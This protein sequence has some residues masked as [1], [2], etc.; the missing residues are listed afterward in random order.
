M[1]RKTVACAAVLALVGAAAATSA[2]A[3]PATQ[4]IWRAP[5]TKAPRLVVPG[6]DAPQRRDAVAIARGH[7]D[8]N[9]G[10]Y[11]VDADEDLRV[12]DV[13]GTPTG[14]TVRFGQVHRGLPVFGAQYLVHLAGG[15]AGAAVSS[16]NGHVFTELDSPTTP[17]L[18]AAEA[19]SLVPLRIRP[20]VADAVSPEGLTIVPVGDG[21]LAYEFVVTG[22]SF[23][24]P[25][26]RRVFINA[27]TGGVVLSYG[28]LRYDGAVTG[29]G[30]TAHGREVTLNA[31]Q[32]G[33]SFELRDRGRSMFSVS[34]GE[35]KT[36]DVLGQA[37]YNPTDGNLVRSSSS[38]FSGANTSSG[39]VDAHWG[40]GEVYEFYL[41]LGRDSIDGMGTT[42]TSIVNAAD[43][44]TGGPLFNAFWD[45]EK[46]IY[47]NP[48]PDELYPLSADLD[49]VGHELTHGVTQSSAGL[50]YLNQSG[51]M[52][53][54]YADYFGQAIDIT[55][56][57]APPGEDGFVGEDLCKVPEPAEWECPLRDLNDGRTT[58]DYLY[59]LSDFDG[60][61]V[62]DN[63][64]IYAGA[65][66]DVR[67][68]LGG[69]KTD[70]IVLKALTEFTTPLDEFIDGR[71]SIVEAARALGS[72][73]EDIALIESIFDAKGI[74]TGWDD[75]GQST[76]RTLVSGIFQSTNYASPQ[77][78]GPRFVIA[79][80]ADMT[81]VE[82]E[83]MQIYVGSIDGS[84]SLAKVGEDTNP[85]TFNDEAP[86]IFGSKVVWTHIAATSSGLDADV[87]SRKLGGGVRAVASGAPWQWYPS[88]DAKTI[89]WEQIRTNSDVWMRRGSRDPVR[90]AGG[91]TEQWLPQ[92]VGDWVAWWLPG[93]GSRPMGISMKNVVTGKTATIKAPSAR[94]F[95][96]PPAV[97]PGYVA[98]Y[99]DNNA[100]GLGSIMKAK[101]GRTA[102]TA[103]VPED[104][105]LSPVWVGG[106]LTGM[107]SGPAL[108]AGS[109]FVA[110][111][112]ERALADKFVARAPVPSARVGR[113]VWLVA[114]GGGTPRLATTARGDQGFPGM[115]DGDLVLWFDGRAARTD[116]LVNR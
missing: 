106:R 66:W 30:R 80:H 45:G 94:A 72:P 67:Q 3:R 18:T 74:V 81:K 19:T 12:L 37:V 46:M 52:D 116:L 62:H 93:D 2:A 89:V 78:S 88:I 65:L 14:D 31:F 23:G 20:M 15:P 92:V 95:L 24:A 84:G 7:L 53:E 76:E 35:I 22:S 110:Y 11:H 90:V 77:V 10:L 73:A 39:A 113:D 6:R 50:V 38:E 101:L 91:P 44:R 87:H 105:E 48:N 56:S 79:N 83:P 103:L 102:T 29:T 112:D 1:I 8:S 16:V 98:W 26:K 40:A 5:G 51:A 27:L 41:S 70:R 13:I 114:V 4:K 85:R 109:D 99:Q 68:Q 17:R 9:A 64:T 63:A 111:T 108:S 43:D 61:G 34:G 75:P 104:S 54:A 58:A 28:E 21:A 33:S 115:G 36:H 59:Y 49:V 60:G 71:A 97:G 96:G 57:P 25:A 69:A 42:I 32:R 86:D 55:D 82:R 47:G 107:T 100:N